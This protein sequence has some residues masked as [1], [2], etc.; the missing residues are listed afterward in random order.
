MEILTKALWND[1]QYVRQ[2]YQQCKRGRTYGLVTSQNIG[3]GCD[4]VCNNYSSDCIVPSVYSQVDKLINNI[5]Y[6]A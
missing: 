5:I 1:A 2:T 3:V 4:E 6:I